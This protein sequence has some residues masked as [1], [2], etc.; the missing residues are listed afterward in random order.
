MSDGYHPLGNG[1][2]TINVKLKVVTKGTGCN[3]IPEYATQGSAAVD[4]FAASL[5]ET[6]V[7]APGHSVMIGTGIA[8]HINNPNIAGYVLPRSGMGAKRGLVP[9][10]LVGLIDSDYQ[11]EIMVSLWNRGD[12]HQKIAPMDRIAQLVFMPV[13][14]AN[15]QVVEEFDAPTVR[16]VGGFGST[17]VGHPAPNLKD[18]GSI[19]TDP[20]LLDKLYEAGKMG[21]GL[22]D[23]VNILNEPITYN[24][25]SW[26]PESPEEQR[27]LVK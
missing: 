12:H 4:L 3:L 24:P 1:P 26:K 14:Q 6:Y 15:F 16:G 22:T 17:G 10:N 9:G 27:K 13:M 11:G 5:T 21:R 7:L 20:S 19:N 8:I 2:T 23:G 25:T 18:L